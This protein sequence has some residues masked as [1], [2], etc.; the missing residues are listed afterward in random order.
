MTAEHVTKHWT[1][2]RQPP[3]PDEPTRADRKLANQAAALVRAARFNDENAIA[4]VLADIP[5]YRIPRLIRLFAAAA[6]A[7]AILT[8]AG[9]D[10]A[11]NLRHL[12]L[13]YKHMHENGIAADDM[14][15]HVVEGNRQY[16]RLIKRR[17]DA[18]KRAA[19][20]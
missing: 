2:S 16:W 19:R 5:P 6:D 14:P 9:F 4:K 12:R 8:A 20:L 3:L 7:D 13:Q 10:D 11:S 18:K 1:I 15:L 17:Y